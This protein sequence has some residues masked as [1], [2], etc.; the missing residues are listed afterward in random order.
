MSKQLSYEDEKAMRLFMKLYRHDG[1]APHAEA[2]G[3]IKRAVEEVVRDVKSDCRHMHSADHAEISRLTAKSGALIDCWELM[4]RDE[5]QAAR[6]AYPTLARRLDE[7][8][9]VATTDEPEG[10]VRS[11]DERGYPGYEDGGMPLG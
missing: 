7:L 4:P 3:I 10:G 1:P 8:V 6:L 2:I 11:M 5:Q 9:R